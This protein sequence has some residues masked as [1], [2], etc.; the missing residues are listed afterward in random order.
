VKSHVLEKLVMNIELP[1]DQ[2]E[3][4]VSLVATG[5]FSSVGEAIREGVGLLISREDL[6]QQVQVGIEQ[7]DRGE[8]IAHDTVFAHLRTLAGGANEPVRP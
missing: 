3:F 4:L 1:P 6:K 8:V 2:Q 5:R 7:A